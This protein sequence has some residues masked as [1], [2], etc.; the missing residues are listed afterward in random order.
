MRLSAGSVSDDFRVLL[1]RFLI[2]FLGGYIRRLILP[3]KKESKI[4]QNNLENR[5]NLNPQTVSYAGVAKLVD[6]VDSKS[7]SSNRVLVRVRSPAINRTNRAVFDASEKEGFSQLYE[8]IVRLKLV[9]PDGWED[10]RNRYG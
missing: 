4:G 6:A 7:T 3:L 9:A 8:K 5:R 10:E 1:S 2:L